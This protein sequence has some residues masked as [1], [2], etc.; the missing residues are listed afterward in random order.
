MRRLLLLAAL[1]AAGC[2]KPAPPPG[3]GPVG[4][5][6][7]PA[8]LAAPEPLDLQLLGGFKYEER[9]ELPLDVKKS[10]GK[11]IKA[12]GFINPTTQARTLTEFLLVK[13]RSSCCFGARPQTN[14][15][16]EVKLIGGKK[17]NY[18][19]DPVTVVGTLKIE[20]RFDGD[21]LLG[22]YWIEDGEIATSH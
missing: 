18:T 8:P 4:P 20:E 6:V 15:Y 13:D 12:T 11:R 16:V 3:P 1:L 19:T 14:H 9:M 10:H 5:K 7:D 17:I 2:D 21:W 22:L